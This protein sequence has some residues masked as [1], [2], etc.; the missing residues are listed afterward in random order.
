MLYFVSLYFI[1]EHLSSVCLDLVMVFSVI[2]WFY[3]F[4][5][6]SDFSTSNILLIFSENLDFLD[7]FFFFFHGDFLILDSLAQKMCVRY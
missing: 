6:C 5:T 2:S 3:F 1:H 4:L 7:E